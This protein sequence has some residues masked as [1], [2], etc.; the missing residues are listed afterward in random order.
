MSLN[1]RSYRAPSIRRMICQRDRLGGL[2][3]TLSIGRGGGKSIACSGSFAQV[4]T[5]TAAPLTGAV[6]PEGDTGLQRCGRY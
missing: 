3:I 2:S 5:L 1:G 6:S 4:A